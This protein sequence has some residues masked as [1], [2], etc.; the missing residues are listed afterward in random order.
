MTEC[1]KCKYVRQPNDT[2][3]PR[4]GIVYDKYKK[5]T[6]KI[7]SNKNRPGI[8]SSV[9]KKANNKHTLVLI[10]SI[11]GGFAI[12]LLAIVTGQLY[13]LFFFI[14]AAVIFYKQGKVKSAAEK[15]E[16]KYFKNTTEIDCFEVGDYVYGFES[17]KQIP[18]VKC[19]V[20]DDDFIFFTGEKRE[21]SFLEKQ[22]RTCIGTIMRISINKV[23]AMDKSQIVSQ[24]FNPLGLVLGSPLL[25]LLG[26]STKHE[27]YC[28]VINWNNMD[29]VESN[30]VF[31]F[32]GSKSANQSDKAAKK[33]SA[34]LIEKETILKDDEKKC[35][36]CAEVIKKEAIVCRYCQ[37]DLQ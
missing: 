35:P 21:E 29:G 6:K 3:C 24:T 36:Y 22:D 26:S 15:S 11:I 4:C 7:K 18:I 2:E 14:V 16:E 9:V 5:N 31:K 34:Y 28:V 30:T 32:E 20:S 27:E 23:F 12:I 13:M 17:D 25:T 8:S 19:Y 10:A 1:P 33:L 37:R